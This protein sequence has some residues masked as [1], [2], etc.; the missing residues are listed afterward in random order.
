MDFKPDHKLI[1]F[2]CGHLVDSVTAAKIIGVTQTSVARYVENKELF[3][4]KVG[5]SLLLVKSECE[6]FK[7]KKPGR[8]R[9]QF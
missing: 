3:G 4:I 5:F 9:K 1:E 2:V 8:P 7:P 6:K